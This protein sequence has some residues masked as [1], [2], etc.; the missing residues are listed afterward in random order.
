MT[1]TT[2]MTLLIMVPLTA[3]LVVAAL[4][5]WWF[6]GQDR[7]RERLQDEL[8]DVLGMDVHIGQQPRFGLWRGP[9][10]TL[11]DIEVS[12]Q[13]QPV[14]TAESVRARLALSGL[15]RGRVKLA[16]LRIV[17]PVLSIERLGPG[18]FNIRQYE[19]QPGTD[20]A[21][22]LRQLQVSDARLNY[23]D[24]VSGMEWLFEHCDLDL[25]SAAGSEKVSAQ[26]LAWLNGNGELRCQR[27][28]QSLSQGELVIDDLSVAFRN[29]NGIFDPSPFSATVF[30]GQLSGEL[31]V[32]LSSSTPA[33]MLTGQ[34][35]GFE[36]GDFLSM[37]NPDQTATGTM[38]LAV[39]L[40]AQGSSWQEVREM[41]AGTLSMKAGELVIDGYDMDSELDDYAATQRF[42]LI[43]AGALFLA[44]PVGLAASRGYTFTG[45]LE[46]SDGS[47]RIDE[48][49]SDWSIENGVAQSRDVAFRTP[50]N[51]LALAGGLDFSRYRFDALQVA[52]LDR[53]GCAIVEQSITGSFDEP[54]VTQ[55]DFLITAIGPLLD[56]IS[57]GVQAIT[58][59]ECEAFYT[60]SIAHP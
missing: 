52:V 53:D 34:L 38:D 7:T 17:R 50:E 23:L 55:P 35:S 54:E 11:A 40:S 9:S 2:R 36:I 58:D 25:R 45:L 29:N 5:A 12:A 6:I 28:S 48:L 19:T 10:V 32:D 41:T 56:L 4:A 3:L 24:Q 44:G 1:K 16:G 49:V 22:L 27:L 46:G 51:R 60:G 57:R 39:E 26:A 21:L 14:A 15:L 18:E 8:A 13:G 30:G 33:F 47:T 31:G 42:N 59:S 43:D 37:L 20:D